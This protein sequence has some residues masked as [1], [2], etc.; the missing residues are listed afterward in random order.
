[1]SK[2]HPSQ[3]KFDWDVDSPAL[4]AKLRMVELPTDDTRDLKEQVIFSD[5]DAWVP[6][7]VVNGN[8]HILPGVPRICKY[9]RVS[10]GEMW[11]ESYV[12]SVVEKL[13]DGLSPIVIPRLANP[14]G[15]G[16]T[17]IIISTPMSESAVAPYLT[18]LAERVEPRGIKVGSYPRW[19]K[20]RNTVTL[21]GK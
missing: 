14:E 16:T 21:V 7:A 13:L 3:P 8:I 15:K 5:E 10:L 9:S 19:G 20:T 11:P 18:Q 6:V 4:K 2:P 1:M 12:L 17:R